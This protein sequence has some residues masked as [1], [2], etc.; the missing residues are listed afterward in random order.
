VTEWRTDEPPRG[1]GD[2]YVLRDE[3]DPTDDES[4][5]ERVVRCVAATTDTC[6]TQLSPLYDV[7]DA[8]ALDA[9]F[10]PHSSAPCRISFRYEGVAVTVVDCG[11]VFVSFPCDRR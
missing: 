8:D 5:S 2:E 11:D 10:P 4:L 3:Y 9:L 7:V 1:V 6:P